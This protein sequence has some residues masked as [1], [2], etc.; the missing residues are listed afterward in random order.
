MLTHFEGSPDLDLA[1]ELAL[2]LA[3][4]VKGIRTSI[5]DVSGVKVPPIS[6]WLPMWLPI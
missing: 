3:P 2:D 6:V 1:P 5:Q 4:D